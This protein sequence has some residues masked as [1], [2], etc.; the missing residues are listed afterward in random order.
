MAASLESRT[1]APMKGKSETTVPRG[2]D[3]VYELKWDGM[4][5]LVFVMRRDDGDHRVRL[6]SSNGRDVTASFPELQAMADLADDYD[7][8]V[9]DGE[10][11]AFA[12]GKPDFTTLQKNRIHVSDRNEA[13]RRSVTTPVLFVAFDLLH[14]DGHDTFALPLENRRSLLEHLDDDAPCWTIC[15]QHEGDVDA[16]LDVVSEKGLEGIVAKRLGSAYRPGRRSPDWVKVKPRPR[17]EFVVGGWLEGRGS[18][19]GGL[20]SLLVGYYDLGALHYAGRAGSGLTVATRLEWQSRLTPSP[21][22]PF[23]QTPPLPR[24]KVAHWCNPDHVVEIAFG[25]WTTGNV[26]RHPVVLGYRSDKRPTEVRRE[27]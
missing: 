5:V 7:G 13:E 8:L 17:Q 3:W 22:C 21:T 11:V 24:D 16:L 6:Q 15:E 19:V 25:E 2:D 26:L 18:S 27:T 12:D 1:I 9:L 4:R 23:A 20:G 10:V 14:L